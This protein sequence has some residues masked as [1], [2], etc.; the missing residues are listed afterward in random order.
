MLNVFRFVWFGLQG[1]VER[2][3]IDAERRLFTNFHRQLFCTIDKWI[4]LNMSDIR[5]LE[6][7]VQEKLNQKRKEGEVCGTRP[8]A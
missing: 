2:Y 1:K 5:R 7:E 4:D 6:D 3:G 8:D